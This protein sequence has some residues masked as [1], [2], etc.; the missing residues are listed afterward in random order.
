MDKVLFTDILNG[1]MHEMKTLREMT[2]KY[3][4]K[5]PLT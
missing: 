2:S 4:L 3:I 5:I 1:E